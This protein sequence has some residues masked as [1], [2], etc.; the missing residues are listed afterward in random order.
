MSSLTVHAPASDLLTPATPEDLRDIVAAAV[1]ADEPLAVEGHGSK[2][3]LGRPIQAA[4]TVSTRAMAGI[5]FY[6]PEELVLSARAGTS[7][8]EIEALVDE[9][10]QRLEFEPMDYG[11]LHGL[12]PGL[13]TIGGVIACN[14]SGPRRLK[15]G[16]A[17]DHILGLAAVS[18]RAEIFKAGGRVVKNVT[19]YDLSKGLTGSYGTLAIMTDVTIKTM[20]KAEAET[21]LILRGLTDEEA[22]GALSAAMGSSA[23]VSGAAHLPYG[24]AARVLDGQLG[25]EAATIVRLEGFGPSVEARSAYLGQALSKVGRMERLEADASR[26]LWK[27]V[28][29]VRPFWDEPK[30]SVWRVSVAPTK[31]PDFANAV[32]MGCAAEAFYDWQGGLVWLR[33][34]EGTQADSIRALVARLGGG[35]ATLVRASESERAATPVFHPQPAP[36]AALSRRLKDQFDPSGI[37]N[38]GRMGVASEGNRA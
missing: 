36:L 27:D 21:T 25:R 23:E 32:R 12:E 17:R 34:E 13:G 7:I 6:E 30:R 11:P 1:S 16:A 29:D 19:G 37:L 8:A 4:R 26:S 38:P 24:I 18:G 9:R 31:G 33:V 35:H 14:L 22:I 2:R 20:P 15:Q 28:R 10:G 3:G 5:N